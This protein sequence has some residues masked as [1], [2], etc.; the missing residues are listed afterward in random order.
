[1]PVQLFY[2]VKRGAKD[3]ESSFIVA[4]YQEILAVFDDMC[5]IVV[6]GIAHV[7]EINGWIFRPAGKVN[8]LTER[9]VFIASA[10]RLHKAV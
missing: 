3:A 2:P 6:R 10:A 5:K 8:H 9:I 4:P 1:M 7:S